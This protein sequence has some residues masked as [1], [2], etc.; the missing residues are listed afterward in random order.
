MEE[1]TNWLPILTSPAGSEISP[2]KHY[3]RS[4]LQEAIKT[5][6]IGTAN[7][8]WSEVQ[9]QSPIGDKQIAES[10]SSSCCSDETTTDNSSLDNL[11][12]RVFDACSCKQQ[13][14]IALREIATMLGASRHLLMDI[15]SVLSIV[16]VVEEQGKEKYLWLGSNRI[17][18]ALQELLVN[19]K[20]S[21]VSIPMNSKDGL[22]ANCK[23]PSITE[24][25][26]RFCLLF[27]LNKYADIRW[28]IAVDT[29]L[30]DVKGKAREEIRST[31]WKISVI[32]SALHLIVSKRGPVFKWSGGEGV[33]AHLNSLA[34]PRLVQRCREASYHPNKRKKIDLEKVEG[35]CFADDRYELSGVCNQVQICRS[36][37]RK[38]SRLSLALPGNSCGSDVE[39]VFQSS[40]AVK[41][42]SIGSTNTECSEELQ[43]QRK[44]TTHSSSTECCWQ[45]CMKCFKN[46]LSMS[47][48][49]DED[50]HNGKNRAF[51]ALD[52]ASTSHTTDVA[53]PCRRS[54]AAEQNL[55]FASNQP[56]A[57]RY[58]NC[59]KA[60]N[61]ESQEGRLC[62]CSLSLLQCSVSRVK[63][64]RPKTENDP[65]Q[66]GPRNVN[67]QFDPLASLNSIYSLQQ[68]LNLQQHNPGFLINFVRYYRQLYHKYCPKSDA[69]VHLP[70]PIRPSYSSFYLLR[71][72]A[73]KVTSFTRYNYSSP[74]G[75]LHNNFNFP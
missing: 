32:L 66:H 36:L 59:R 11:C 61:K 49:K 4:P 18:D 69:L 8:L 75:I 10:P 23:I 68:V 5:T 3:D 27:L 43:N 51:A 22:S 30:S 50:D 16:R 14:V 31:L 45:K 34:H 67:W 63:G 15:F 54:S 20:Q 56:A 57:A 42:L 19:Q 60:N 47:C 44:N 53:R 29:L 12:Q 13:G 24:L 33:A 26:K 58:L 55:H 9:D 38:R 65:A 7:V 72:L 17:E 52:R 21:N 46:S 48:S 71:N 6:D 37:P 41:C 25:G 1:P 35:D 2:D 39:K 73:A 40:P 28:E 62:N 70:F 74:N 64:P